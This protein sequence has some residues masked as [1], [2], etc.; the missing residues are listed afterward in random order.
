MIPFHVIVNKTAATSS[1]IAHTNMATTDFHAECLLALSLKVKCCVP[2][3]CTFG[4]AVNTHYFTFHGCQ[5]SP[6]SS[7]CL[8]EL[9]SWLVS[10]PPTNATFPADAQTE[11]QRK[12]NKEQ[13]S[14]TNEG[15]GNF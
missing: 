10:D 8:P 12:H 11:P 13:E 5:L 4:T 3:Q 1:I 6:V 15:I 2:S 7:F 9:V 14:L